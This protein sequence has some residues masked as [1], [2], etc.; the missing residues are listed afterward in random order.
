M[1]HRY[2]SDS[3]HCAFA[4][5]NNHHNCQHHD[6]WTNNEHLDPSLGNKAVPRIFVLAILVDGDCDV[7]FAYNF[8]FHVFHKLFCYCI[9]DV[10][11]LFYF[12]SKTSI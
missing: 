7:N 12:I 2:H 11:L 4:V 1:C 10:D 5:D 8:V 3:S 6:N 9:C